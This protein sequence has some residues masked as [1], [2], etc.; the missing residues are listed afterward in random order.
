[1]LLDLID[2]VFAWQDEACQN[3]RPVIVHC[4]D[5]FSHSGLFAIL[6]ILCEKMEEDEEVDVYRTIKH[7]KRQRTQF[8]TNYVSISCDYF[9]YKNISS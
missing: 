7:C 5:G 8:M 1:M 9:L 2:G 6:A 4:Q 3:E